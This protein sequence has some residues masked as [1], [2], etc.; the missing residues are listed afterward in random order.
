MIFPKMLKVRQKLA[1]R[2]VDSIPEKIRLELGG[3]GIQDKI[4]QGD[5]IAITV[6]SRGVR[7]ID[8]IT[9]EV[10][11]CLENYGAKPFIIPAMGSHGGATP[12]GQAN[13]LAH[14]GVTEEYIG[15]PIKATM[16]VVEIGQT[17]DGLKV[18]LDR[19]ASEADHIL[20]MNRVKPHTDFFGEI[21]SGLH[22]IMTIGLGKHKG[23][24]YYHQAA[25]EYGLG[26]IIY[27]V[28][29][30]VLRNTSIL[31][32]IGIVENGYDETAEIKA[33]LPAEFERQEKELLKKAQEFIAKLPFD[34]IDVLIVDQI[35]KDISGTGMD[36]NVTGRMMAPLFTPEPE[37][38]SIK[39]ILVSDLTKDTDG[40]ALGI[41]AA[42]FCNTRIIEKIDKHVMYTNGLTGLV[43]EKVR[44]PMDFPTDKE[45]LTAALQTIGLVGTEKARVV[46]IKDTLHMEYLELSTAFAEQLKN[47]ND[48]IVIS[49]P[50]DIKF[51]NKGNF[52]FIE[53]NN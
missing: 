34:Y 36:T 47:R 7:N 20:V 8:V 5:S 2:K 31:C 14:Y 41:G 18:Y 53:E 16:E 28:G 22:K 11:H 1:D 45:M 23:A 52:V 24:R 50:E 19:Y 3:I 26:H 10:V 33:I 32:G 25:V 40:N 37:I 43:P 49:G 46:H 12:E 6:G 17:V 44:L 21:E 39:R 15:A 27:T 29:Q 42:D 51:D 38:P 48:L 4:N 30:T 13:V 9:K 35:G